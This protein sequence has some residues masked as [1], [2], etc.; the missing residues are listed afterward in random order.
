[1]RYRSWLVPVSIR[2]DSRLM[3]VCPSGQRERAVN[4]LALAF[5]G[6]NPSA[7]NLYRLVI[8]LKSAGREEKEDNN[9]GPEGRRTPGSKFLAASGPT[10]TL[11]NLDILLAVFFT[12]GQLLSTCGTLS[13][14][15]PYYSLPVSGVG[16][17]CSI[18]MNQSHN[19]GNFWFHTFVYL[20]FK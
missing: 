5:E 12:P 15:T 4:P 10:G 7:P 11:I 13:N 1:M 20:I 9:V 8:S 6:S 2:S 16:K 18:T 14:A 17:P 19:K 3:G